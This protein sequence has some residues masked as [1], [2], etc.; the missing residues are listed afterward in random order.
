MFDMDNLNKTQKEAVIETD[1]P[2]MI[3]AGAGSGKTRTLVSR[4][5]YI[6]DE[7]KLSPHRLLAL[8]FSNK[9]AKEMRER[10]AKN[11]EFDL[12]TLQITTFHS[13]CAR[14]LRSEAPYLG[15]SRS[16][17]IYDSSEQ[18]SVAKLVLSRFG[19]S[20]KE[21]SPYEV[22][23][24][25]EQLK[26]VGHYEGAPYPE[27][28][29]EDEQFYNFF[30]EYEKEV[31]RAN[32]IDFGGLITATIKLFEQ[33]PDVLESYQKRF[34]Y[35]LVDEYQD[36]NKAQFRLLTMLA[37]KKRN[38]CVVGDEDQSIYSWRGADINNI[39]DF[40]KIFPDAKILKLEQN[41]RSSKNIIDAAGC[42]ISQNKMRKG[43]NMWTSNPDGESIEVLELANEKDEAQKV[44][45]NIKLVTKDGGTLDDVAV[46][47]RTNSQSRQ[48]EDVLR[49]YGLPYRVVGGIKFYERKEI[50]D[51]ISYL[52]VIVNEKDS[53]AISRIINVPARGIGATTLRKVENI[54]IQLNCSLWE[55]LQKII[56]NYEDYTDLRFSRNVRS[57]LEG[58]IT[59]IEDS[60][61]MLQEKEK[62][63][64]IL[65][66]IL[67]ESGYVEFLKQKKDHE[68]MARLENI[69]EFK[70]SIHQFETSNENLGLLDFLET[71]TL[72]T[73][74]EGDDSDSG[75]KGEISLMTVHGAKGLEFPYVFITGAEENL[76][77]SYKSLETGE[78]S[79][80]EE[81]RL[82]YVAMTRAMK[83]LFI[84][85]SQSRMLFGQT[86][87][88]GPSRF[89]YEIPNDFYDWKTFSSSKFQDADES[90]WDEFNQDFYPDEE[91]VFQRGEKLKNTFTKKQK[92]LHAIYGEGVVT[93]CSGTGAS[94][95]VTI[96]FVDGTV[97]KFL[98]K[99]AP[100][101]L[102]S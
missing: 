60:K 50:K 54:S 47:Y 62:P 83:K 81:R 38:L 65:D 44:V 39:L 96:K 92:V 85:F 97:K 90:Q 67:N 40:E 30:L 69:D 71:I 26:N 72:D 3:L 19:I 10:V 24:F 86:K 61:R 102:L 59:L 9:A 32:A 42:V 70:N 18:K 51:I 76:F 6:L 5:S 12:G 20:Q 46:F 73:S 43:K 22:I 29:E 53:L 82:F 48:I 98:V 87:F 64:V 88:N 17:S 89:I 27:E 49:K 34:N 36:T 41:Y 75:L 93:D 31:T 66:K 14:V 52:R 11:T 1:G 45:E 16:F 100:V 101:S 94:E 80:E 4:I 15:L 25:I 95:K 78:E 63:S 56:F 91:V 58:F 13:F 68:S 33:N 2:M 57:S 74:V 8:T 28:F 7:K 77:P 35:I 37:E 21:I 99:F 79:I 84:C 23:Y 55:S